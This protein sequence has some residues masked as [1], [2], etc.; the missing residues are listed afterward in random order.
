MP[1]RHAERQPPGRRV[2]ERPP[3]PVLAAGEARDLGRAVH[4]ALEHGAQRDADRGDRQLRGEPAPPPAVVERDHGEPRPARRRPRPRRGARSSTRTLPRPW[5]RAAPADRRCTR[6]ARDQH[7]GCERGGNQRVLRHGQPAEREHDRRERDDC[8]DRSRGPARR[9]REQEARQHE[10]EQRC[11]H[12]EQRV[13]EQRAVVEGQRGVG[14]PC[15]RHQEE[16]VPG[17]VAHPRTPVARR[18][19]S[20]IAEVAA[21][22]GMD[23]RRRDAPVEQRVQDD[24]REQAGRD[25]QRKPARRDVG[26]VVALR[27][28]SDRL[29]VGH[30]RDPLLQ[31]AAVIPRGRA[32]PRAGNVR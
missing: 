1:D 14:E 12:C 20:G 10:R 30:A 6:R 28:R 32:R 4:R 5:P 25:V 23:L 11:Q 29:R 19:V 13:G 17:V 31:R 8:G 2:H 7:G 27:R 21:L 24:E 15:G 26:G 3:R 16:A 9:T 22:V 18:E